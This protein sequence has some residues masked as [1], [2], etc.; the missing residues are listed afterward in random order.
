MLSRM[1]VRPNDERLDRVQQDLLMAVKVSEEEISDVAGSPDLYDVLR[2]R[3]AA[4]RAQKAGTRM[5]AEDLRAD[6]RGRRSFGPSL[7]SRPSLRWTLTAAAVLLLAAFATL[8][9][10]PR[11]SNQSAQI[12][13]LVP[14]VVPAPSGAVQPPDDSKKEPL[15][16]ARGAKLNSAPVSARRASYRQHRRVDL[17]RRIGRS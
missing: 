13:P 3:I 2:A 1:K 14:Q 4:G 11:Q 6:E 7:W 15:D 9:L 5:A 12:A 10:L 16:I 8:L 17:Y